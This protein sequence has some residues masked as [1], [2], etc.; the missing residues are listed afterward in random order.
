MLCCVIVN[1]GR[2]WTLFISVYTEKDVRRI[3]IYIYMVNLHKH[4]K[5]YLQFIYNFI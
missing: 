4:I 1:M 2:E 3:Y 5:E